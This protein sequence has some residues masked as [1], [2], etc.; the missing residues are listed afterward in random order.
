MRIRLVQIPI[1][2]HVDIR[3]CYDMDKWMSNN[4]TGNGVALE[5]Y[6]LDASKTLDVTTKESTSQRAIYDIPAPIQQ[7]TTWTGK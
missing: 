5:N 4:G 7:V 2:N 6:L 1:G 3:K